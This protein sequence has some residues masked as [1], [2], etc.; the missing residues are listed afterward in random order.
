ML[1]LGVWICVLQA[2]ARILVLS[3]H[4]FWNSLCLTVK[5]VDLSFGTLYF[6]KPVPLF[7][8]F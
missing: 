1:S 6:G 7:L 3:E 5:K 2:F 8:Y 4:T